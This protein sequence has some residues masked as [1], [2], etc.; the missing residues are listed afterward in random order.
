VT[1]IDQDGAPIALGA[2]E[3]YANQV[4]LRVS[5]YD[6]ALT[7]SLDGVHGAKELVTVLMSPPHARSLLLL[8]DRYM[9][10]YE[11]TVGPVSLPDEL[12]RRLQ[13]AQAEDKGDGG[14]S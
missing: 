14:V 5:P 13:G 4:G 9:Q 3:I 10:H 7:F 8:L 1:D 6:V 12:V 2:P 11:D